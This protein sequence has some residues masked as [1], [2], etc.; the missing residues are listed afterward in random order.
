MPVSLRMLTALL[1]ACR[2][3]KAPEQGVQVL[4]DCL[5]RHHLQP[6]PVFL[7]ILDAIL[8]KYKRHDLRQEVAALLQSQRIRPDNQFQDESSAG[9]ESARR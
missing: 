5:G 3:A 8:V 6:D 2:E 4:H 7:R 9:K 1:V